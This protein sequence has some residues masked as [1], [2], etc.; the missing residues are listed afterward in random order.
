MAFLTTAVIAALYAGFILWL[1]RKAGGWIALK[2]SRLPGH[3][4]GDAWQNLTTI[5]RSWFYGAPILL[6]Y[7]VIATA[8]GILLVATGN[9]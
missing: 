8:V 4:A 5:Q 3:G 9:G 7:A 1:L 6:T 2:R